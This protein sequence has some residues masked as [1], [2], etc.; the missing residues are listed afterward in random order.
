[1]EAGNSAE[2]V[3]VVA[4]TATLGKYSRI[5]ILSLIRSGGKRDCHIAARMVWVVAVVVDWSRTKMQSEVDFL[6]QTGTDY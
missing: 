2:E 4:D 1:M 6:D 3:V 5:A